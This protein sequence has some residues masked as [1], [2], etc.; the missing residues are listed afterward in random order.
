MDRK[1]IPV[2]RFKLGFNI[3]TWNEDSHCLRKGR[4]KEAGRCQKK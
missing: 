1:K 4:N 3:Y 2:L